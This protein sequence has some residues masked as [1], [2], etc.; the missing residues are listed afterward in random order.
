MSRPDM[1][2]RSLSYVIVLIVVFLLAYI[3]AVKFSHAEPPPGA[4]DPVI[5]D[6]FRSLK[7]PETGAMCCSESD[8]RGVLSRI[9]R[10]HLQAFIDKKSFGAQAPDAWVEV[11]DSA[12][13]HQHD[14]PLGSDVACY[15]QGHILCFIQGTQI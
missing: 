10:G 4:H 2:C 12:V 1:S 15:F 13:L 11:S 5:S 8:C 3:I 14:N 9:E 6:W 7:N